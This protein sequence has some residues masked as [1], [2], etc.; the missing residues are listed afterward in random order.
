MSF[1]DGYTFSDWVS[2]NLAQ[3]LGDST[4]TVK[5]N[6]THICIYECCAGLLRSRAKSTKNRKFG[7]GLRENWRNVPEIAPKLR[8]PTKNHEDVPAQRLRCWASGF[9]REI[10]EEQ[11]WTPRGAVSKVRSPSNFSERRVGLRSFIFCKC[12][13]GSGFEKTGANFRR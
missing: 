13:F 11:P 9:G 1:W 5:P 7:F 6:P 8:S 2:T 12:D 3:I 10:L 4:K